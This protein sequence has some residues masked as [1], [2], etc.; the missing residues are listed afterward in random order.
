MTKHGARTYIYMNTIQRRVQ[1]ARPIHRGN[2]EV[3]CYMYRRYHLLGVVVHVH[4]NMEATCKCIHTHSR[5]YLGP[6]N[7]PIL[8][9]N[10]VCNIHV[11]AYLDH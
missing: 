9:I 5:R 2:L 7:L 10:A 6:L 4:I 11:I 3:V 8:L 1:L